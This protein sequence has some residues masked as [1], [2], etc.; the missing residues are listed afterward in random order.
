MMTFIHIQLAQHG[1]QAIGKVNICFIWVEP[2]P[3]PFPILLTFPAAALHPNQPNIAVRLQP[4]GEDKG[5]HG[6]RGMNG[7][8]FWLWPVINRLSTTMIINVIGSGSATVNRACLYT[9]GSQLVVL[10]LCTCLNKQTL[11]AAS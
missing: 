2:G 1:C 6:N 5:N 8:P 3:F 11:Y 7:S 4:L 9:L 10:V